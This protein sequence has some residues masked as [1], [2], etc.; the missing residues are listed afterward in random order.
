ML[1]VQ[2]TLIWQMNNKTVYNLGWG[3]VATFWQVS[4]MNQDQNV[5]QNEMK[6]M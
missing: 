2:L 3:C 5:R 1:N 4:I 6:I